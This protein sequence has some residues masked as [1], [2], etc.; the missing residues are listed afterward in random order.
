MSVRQRL[1]DLWEDWN[2]PNIDPVFAG[3]IM[4]K[5]QRKQDESSK[6]SKAAGALSSDTAKKSAKYWKD[7]FFKRYPEADTS[8][9]GTLSWPEYKAAKAKLNAGK[10][11]KR[12]Q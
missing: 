10:S 6:K 12:E 5:A 3:L 7:Q 1:H 4:G 2:K 8:K 9:D 11:G